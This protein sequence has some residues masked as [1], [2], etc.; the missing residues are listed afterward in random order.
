MKEK[1]KEIINLKIEDLSKYKGIYNMID[2]VIDDVFNLKNFEIEKLSFLELDSEVLNRLNFYK[3]IL[4]DGVYDLFPSDINK[5]NEILLNI[6]HKISSCIDDNLINTYSNLLDKLDNYEFDQNDI[7]LICTLLKEEKEKD[8]DIDIISYM[9]HISL[10]MIE[11]MKYD[12]N[13]VK[14]EKPI[15]KKPEELKEDEELITTNLSTD[16]LI[17]LF[18]K[19][20]LD[21]MLF[22]KESRELIE[23]YGKYDNINK[24]L[25]LFINKEH[26]NIESYIKI[27]SK[28]LANIF[29]YSNYDLI[30]NV[31]DKLKECG[32][33]IHKNFKSIISAP[34]KFIPRKRRYLGQG[35]G[36]LGDFDGEIG[37]NEDFL[38]N[39]H[40][41]R[42][43]FKEIKVDDISSAYEKCPSIFDLSYKHNKNALR[44]FD[45]YYIKPEC[46]LKSL[47]SF[48]G[49]PADAIDA[50]IESDYNG[51]DT[52]EYLKKNPSKFGLSPY[53]S[54]FYKLYMARKKGYTKEELF[55]TRGFKFYDSNFLDINNDNDSEIVEQYFSDNPKFLEYENAIKESDNSETILTDFK[56]NKLIIDALDEKYLDNDIC[57]IINGIRISK[58]KVQRFLNTL[59]LNRFDID[60]DALLYSITKNS[61]L[62]EEEYKMIENEVSRLFTTV[63]RRK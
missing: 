20:G 62:N 55:S 42:E 50:F 29:I 9:K 3:K 41:F 38:K 5:L 49:F 36:I 24:I 7:E 22:N 16:D 13:P 53:S 61:I 35:N 54:I 59:I 60:K 47:S 1:L 15:F 34:S 19:Y 14:E 10:E 28:Q 27:K 46:F 33:D 57:Y 4:T 51:Y 40:M 8:N 12:E 23:K 48:R 44:Q 2:S 11:R 30:S 31:F 32:I 45:L 6:K 18:N 17:N 37:H 25:D 52:L 43:V 26:I 39:I 56:P 21:Y 63:E 58:F